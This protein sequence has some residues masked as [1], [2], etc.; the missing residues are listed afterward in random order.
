MSIVECTSYLIVLHSLSFTNCYGYIIYPD[1]YLV[2][3]IFFVNSISISDFFSNILNFLFSFLNFFS[4]FYSSSI[5]Y[6]IRALISTS[7][8]DLGYAN[9]ICHH[10][11]A[12]FC[13]VLVT[14]LGFVFFSYLSQFFWNY[15]DGHFRVVRQKSLTKKEAHFTT[16]LI[17]ILDV[18]P[19]FMF[20]AFFF[21]DWTIYVPN[22]MKYVS[23]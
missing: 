3:V 11:F 10:T 8:I 23:L 9:P 16:V 21:S 2:Y 20:V 12:Y 22:T 14:S 17:S 5:F 6:S 7:E 1:F 15:D 4:V 19:Y 13:F 18:G